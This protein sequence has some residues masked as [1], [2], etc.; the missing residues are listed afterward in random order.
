AGALRRG[1]KP[2]V[3]IT[4]WKRMGVGAALLVGALT[5]SAQQD[6][7]PARVAAL[8]DY[9]GIVNPAPEDVSRLAELW[10]RAQQAGLAQEERRRAFRDLYLLWARLHG[11]DLTARPQALDGLA[12]FATMAFAGGGRMDLALPEPRS[13]P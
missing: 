8:L 9:S 3:G 5:L 2:M 6:D 12:G 13:K 4:P 11:R 7:T 10:T 1:R